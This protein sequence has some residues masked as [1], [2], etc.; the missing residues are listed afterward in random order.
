VRQSFLSSFTA[1]SAPARRSEPQLLAEGE[2]VHVVCDEN[3]KR[4][5]L[6]EQYTPALRTLM[7]NNPPHLI[8]E[9]AIDRPD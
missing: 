3:L 1:F 5:P 2:T 8:Q 9:I 7:E 4:M 6:P